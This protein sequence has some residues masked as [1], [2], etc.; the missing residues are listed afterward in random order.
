MK[1]LFALSCLICFC[2]LSLSQSAL[3]ARNKLMDLPETELNT[4]CDQGSAEHCYALGIKYL[5]IIMNNQGDTAESL[6]A[7]SREKLARACDLGLAESCL[8]LGLGLEVS[9]SLSNDPQIHK[10][11]LAVLQRGCDLGDSESCAQVVRL[12]N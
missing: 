9:A 4:Q 1:A 6:G 3:A 2:T 5:E 12:S 10:A 8:M 7:L 11:A